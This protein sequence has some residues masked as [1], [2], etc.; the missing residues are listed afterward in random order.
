MESDPNV[1]GTASGAVM[2]AIY[3]AHEEAAKNGTSPKN[4]DLLAEKVLRQP[5]FSHLGINETALNLEKA[6]ELSKS[7]SSMNGDDEG[8]YQEI[9]GQRTIGLNK[10]EVDDGLKSIADAFGNKVMP[11]ELREGIDNKRISRVFVI[12]AKGQKAK[13]TARTFRH[14][15]EN[16][17][18]PD[19]IIGEALRKG[20]LNS[21][22]Y[23]N[24]KVVKDEIGYNGLIDRFND[25]SIRGVNHLADPRQVKRMAVLKAQIAVANED[26]ETWR[27]AK[28]AEKYLLVYDKVGHFINEEIKKNRGDQ[29]T[30]GDSIGDLFTR[31]GPGLKIPSSTNKPIRSQK[32]GF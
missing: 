30:I 4:L 12:Q 18:D 16:P 6:K 8:G 26:P 1:V 14:L 10:T 29:R 5:K 22:I 28:P 3:G 17:N 11:P 23:T 20:T 13:L 19:D 2:S 7:L 31:F 21:H 15:T 25:D 27:V 32:E 9:F 24:D